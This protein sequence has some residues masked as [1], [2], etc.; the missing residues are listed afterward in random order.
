MKEHYHFPG[1]H[2]SLFSVDVTVLARDPRS[3]R[4][5]CLVT[6]W[7]GE[8]ISL[9]AAKDPTELYWDWCL[10]FPGQHF[11]SL[12]MD[13]QGLYLA[14]LARDGVYLMDADPGKSSEPDFILSPKD[15]DAMRRSDA[16]DPT[17]CR[18]EKD[19][20]LHAVC[21]EYERVYDFDTLMVVDAMTNFKKA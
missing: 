13:Q 6:S 17:E 3:W 12:C 9:C 8:E 19:N 7:G 11:Y 20:R 2:D 5:Y 21:A 4:Y 18:F 15:W 16:F 10:S 14:A 1:T